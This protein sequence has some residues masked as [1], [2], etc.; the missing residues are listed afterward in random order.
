MSGDKEKI[1]KIYLSKLKQLKK[2]NKKYYEDS[3]PKI[4]D[5]EYDKLKKNILDLE[6]QYKFLKN[7]YTSD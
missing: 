6:D 3:K 2:H 5:S 1:K 7:Q 4:L